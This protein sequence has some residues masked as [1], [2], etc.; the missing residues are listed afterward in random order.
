MT[1]LCF[2]GL[3]FLVLVLVQRIFLFS[4][5][6]IFTVLIFLF[7][8]YVRFFKIQAINSTGLCQLVNVISN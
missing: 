5:W 3:A 8:C 1:L 7:E 6:D 4:Q 2:L